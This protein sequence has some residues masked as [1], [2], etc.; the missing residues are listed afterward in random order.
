MNYKI[1]FQYR[2]DKT[3]IEWII[4]EQIIN[5]DNEEMAKTKAHRLFGNDIEILQIDEYYRY[6]RMVLPSYKRIS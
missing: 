2:S 5:A 3:A 4:S 6:N 1:S